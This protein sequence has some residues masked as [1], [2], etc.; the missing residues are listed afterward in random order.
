MSFASKRDIARE[1]VRRA[2]DLGF[3]Y[4]RVK[5]LRTR[6]LGV[7][8]ANSAICRENVARVEDV[9]Q[10]S[11]AWN[12]RDAQLLCQADDVFGVLERLAAVRRDI[13]LQA[14]DAETVLPDAP[15]G[16]FAW[17]PARAPF[18]E[19]YSCE[20]L[21][22]AIAREA[23]AT[24]ARGLRLTGY[25][26]AMETLAHAFTTTGHDHETHD[27]GITIGVTVDDA[28]TGA[29][30]QA[31]RASTHATRAEFERLLAAATA[32]ATETAESSLGPAALLPGDYTVVLHPSATF[33][34][35]QTMLMYGL[36]DKRKIDEGRTYLAGK[37]HE[38][39]FPPALR[40]A[41]SASLALPDGG[42]YADSPL[43]H[44]GVLC[45]SLDL[46]RD[47]RLR[48]L[49]TSPFWAKTHGGRETF[50]PA[51]A[52]PLSLSMGND[53]GAPRDLS[54]LIG[55]TE[56]GVYVANMWYLRMVAEMDGTI[57][58]MTRDG[59]YEIKDGKLARPLLN[60][61]WHENP[62]R[63]LQA[64]D[65]ATREELLLGRSRLSGKSRT[66]GLA[67]LPAVR[68]GGF[69]FSSVTKF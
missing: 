15:S 52:P 47:G 9:F 50:S 23:L 45:E 67:A 32:E 42:V 48:D 69:H 30:G 22:P 61:R 33:D 19:L 7:R 16:S 38:L 18:E 56:R 20:T 28:K 55:R 12:N 37:M 54:E 3:D 26:E 63:V 40:L 53:A 35:V 41:Q 65:L 14:P 59:V 8:V 43:N 68:V 24:R 6:T 34:I 4:L 58:G 5:A 31:Q 13:E 64:I 21:Y 17:K 27:H 2:A 11:A 62:V 60:M 57:T 49:H 1:S 36:F 10:I 46:V 66:A 25:V 29:A 51:S 39:Q 44:R